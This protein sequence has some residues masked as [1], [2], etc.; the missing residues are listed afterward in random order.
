MLGAA[1]EF[2]AVAKDHA[3]FK[4]KLVAEESGDRG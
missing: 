3:I 2:V 4:R 1:W